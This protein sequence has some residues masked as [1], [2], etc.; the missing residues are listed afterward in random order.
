VTNLIV[1]VEVVMS[2]AAP[3]SR[4][5]S[6][7]WSFVIWLITVL[8]QLIAAILLFILVGTAGTLAVAGSGGSGGLIVGALIA[9]ASIG[10]VFAIV[11]LIIVFKMRDGRN[12]A[13]IVLTILAALQIISTLVQGGNNSFINWIGFATLVI[14]TVLMFVPASNQ[15]FSRRGVVA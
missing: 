6:V 3:S 9:T 5:T 15:Y 2:T 10:L 12:W 13:R 14:A 4:P 8:L 11:E 7:T 1:C